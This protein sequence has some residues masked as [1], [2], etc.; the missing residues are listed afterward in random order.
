[1]D[2]PAQTFSFLSFFSNLGRKKNVSPIEN[3]PS[4]FL[5]LTPFL[6][7][8]KDFSYPPCLFPPHLYF[9]SIFPKPGQSVSKSFQGNWLTK[10]RL[11]GMI[12]RCTWQDTI[13]NIK[14][15]YL[16]RLS[17]FLLDNCF[18]YHV[19]KLC[20]GNMH[21]HILPTKFHFAP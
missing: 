10:Y 4:I 21:G 7:Q 9:F 17:I 13:E 18:H 1:M 16:H 3:N 15:K 19:P 11:H 8:T 2:P 6:S 14:W 20:E 5:F 12:N